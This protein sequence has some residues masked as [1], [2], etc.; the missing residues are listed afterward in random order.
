M[1]HLLLI[2]LRP[3]TEWRTW[4]AVRQAWGGQVCVQSA[5]DLEAALAIVSRQAPYEQ[6]CH[7]SLVLLGTGPY[8]VWDP[9]KLVQL[10]TALR[11]FQVPLIGLADTS[12]ALERLRAQRAPLDGVILSPVQ[13]DALQK[14][15]GSLKLSSQSA[16]Q[17]NRRGQITHLVKSSV[18]FVSG[19]WS[20]LASHMTTRP[21]SHA[22]LALQWVAMVILVAAIVGG[23]ANASASSLPGDIL[24][25]VKLAVQQTRLVL[26][27][28]EDTRT[29]LIEEFSAQQ[30]GDIQAAERVGR[31][32]NIEFEGEL[33]QIDD[34][35]WGV[36]GLHVK[37][38]PGMSKA[39]LPAPG[40][41]V[42]VKGRLPGDG[43]LIASNM[44]VAASSPHM[45]GVTNHPTKT[46]DEPPS[47]TPTPDETPAVQ[48]PDQPPATRVPPSAQ[49]TKT[50]K[51]LDPT[52]EPKVTH[53]P[54]SSNEEKGK[55]EQKPDRS[56]KPD[57]K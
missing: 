36:G 42:I 19:H 1:I 8:G 57:K 13:P 6:S 29:K 18:R 43:S 28:N 40:T 10:R 55:S 35:T 2:N 27:P 25:P 24:Y 12:W 26:T 45:S 54:Q 7:P 17:I 3:E 39:A 37:L 30:L 48:G 11:K 50:A 33:Q 53:V 16:L 41:R 46:P 47:S 32:A 14:L 44:T 34:T 22:R 51:E 15:A 5:I 9:I 23:T 38:Q 52:R 56:V 49:S 4:R 31:R 20:Q 21:S